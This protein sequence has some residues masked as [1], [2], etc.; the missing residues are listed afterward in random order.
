MWKKGSPR[1]EA[2]E[3]LFNV[4]ISFYYRPDN[5]DKML[6]SGLRFSKPPHV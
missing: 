1:G 2:F 5:A 4:E 3:M 6:K